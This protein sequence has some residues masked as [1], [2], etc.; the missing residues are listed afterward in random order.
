MTMIKKNGIYTMILFITLFF[1]CTVTA[2]SSPST[3]ELEQLHQLFKREKGLPFD[4]LPGTQCS[5]PNSCSNIS[6]GN[7]TSL[8]CRCNDILNV[9]K[10]N[11]GQYCWGSVSLTQNTNCPAVPTSC[12]SSFQEQPTC[13]CN[14]ATV[15]CV[16]QHNNYCFATGSNGG[17]LSLA[18]I[19]TA[20]SNSMNGASSTG[21][22]PSS[23]P[24]SAHSLSS[25]YVLMTT[26]LFI[27]VSFYFN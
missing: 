22:N 6:K 26:L 1:T 5:I 18:P 3:L 10:N 11:S 19:P 9:C 24:S 25:S 13:L 23:T 12:S 16:N 20:P 8:N 14:S 7:N 15:L 27:L 17:S 2:F 21:T 4:T